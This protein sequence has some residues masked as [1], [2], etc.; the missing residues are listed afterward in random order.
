MALILVTIAERYEMR[1]C[2]DWAVK[3]MRRGAFREG[4]AIL[5][6]PV[7]LFQPDVAAFDQQEGALHQR[8]GEFP[9]RPVVDA[10]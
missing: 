9:P 1:R 8:R 3:N 7:M 6:K 4:S 5:A 10:G 2:A